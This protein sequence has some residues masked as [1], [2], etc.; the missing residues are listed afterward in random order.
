MKLSVLIPCYNERYMVAELVDRVLAAPLPDGMERELIIVDDGSTDGTRAIL[1]RVAEKHPREIVYFPKEK[2]EGKGSAIRVAISLATGDFC[3]FQDADLEYDP[4]DYRRLLDP[5]LA[6]Q[7]DVVYGSRYLPS[8]RRRVLYYWH[9]LANRAV[10]VFSNML[11]DL[12]LTDMETCYKV[13][14]TEVLKTIPLRSSRFGIEP[15]ITAKIAKRGLRVYEVP[16]SYH[17]RTY[18]EGK[19]IGWRDAFQ[20][21]G[22]AFKYWVIDDAYDPC[23]A[24]EYVTD[25]ARA[26]RV[27][28]WLA[29]VVRPH[30]GERVLEIGAG[31]GA[32]TGRL[33]PRERYV[34]SEFRDEHLAVLENLAARSRRLEVGRVD[35]EKAEYFEA[36]HEQVDTVLCA[37]QLHR[38]ADPVGTLRNFHH[39][40]VPGGRV[41]VVAAQ[42]KWLECP[43]DVG[44]G[45]RRRFTRRTLSEAME[46]AGLQVE[47][48]FEF[49]RVGVPGWVL[50][51]LLLRSRRM[52]RWQLKAYDA[53]TWFWRRVDWLLPWSGLALI[54]V[55]RK[56]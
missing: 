37:N 2:N 40:L 36:W 51:G 26:H 25:L 44:L 1:E 5:L 19:K 55:G 4:R 17:A 20:A 13:F 54:A 39:A 38:V 21:F 14:R 29:D 30:L 52:S 8:A 32:L 53:T 48:L 6:G 43:L 49:N 34:A 47:R 33:L 50:N 15:E 16:I 18:Q 24:P 10:T 22:T 9:G 41:V 45:H 56:K 12:G 46:A 23:T 31:L 11:T 28:R 7:A 42:S 35:P 27:N 3:V